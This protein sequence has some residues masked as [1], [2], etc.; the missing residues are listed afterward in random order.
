MGERK[1]AE[2]EKREREKGKRERR[3][4]RRSVT[5]LFLLFNAELKGPQ[6]TFQS[7]YLVRTNLGISHPSLLMKYSN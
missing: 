7:P 4:R 6:A 3:E 1:K 5:H 2:K